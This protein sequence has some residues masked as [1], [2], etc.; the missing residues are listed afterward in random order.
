MLMV[1]LSQAGQPT[2]AQTVEHMQT[3]QNKIQIGLTVAE[4]E[5]EQLEALRQIKLNRAMTAKNTLSRENEMHVKTMFYSYKLNGSEP[6][7]ENELVLDK[8]QQQ[9]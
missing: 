3:V 9:I 8:K 5:R 2:V 7:V 4:K 6:P 1:P